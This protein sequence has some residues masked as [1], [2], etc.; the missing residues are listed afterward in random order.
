V[1][2]YDMLEGD[3][4]G[5]T[6]RFPVLNWYRL[7]DIDAAEWGRCVG[8]QHFCSLECLL[9]FIEKLMEVG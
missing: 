7:E 9:K 6:E 3:Q 1:A 4:C 8:E 5:K 2:Q